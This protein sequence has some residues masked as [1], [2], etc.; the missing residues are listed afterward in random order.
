MDVVSLNKS[1]IKLLRERDYKPQKTCKKKQF[2]T[3]NS[4]YKLNGIDMRN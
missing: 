2:N 4:V 1:G 3:F